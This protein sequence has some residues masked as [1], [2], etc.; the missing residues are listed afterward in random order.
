MVCD[1]VLADIHVC[2]NVNELEGQGLAYFLVSSPEAILC[3]G[4]SNL[5]EARVQVGEGAETAAVTL[6]LLILGVIAEIFDGL[7]NS[8]HLHMHA[9]EDLRF[10]KARLQRFTVVALGPYENSSA[11]VSIISIESDV[12]PN[13]NGLGVE[14]SACESLEASRGAAS[15]SQVI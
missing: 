12:S 4:E 13:V 3:V 8:N 10:D 9:R 15:V 5:P 7:W 1:V 6:E 11:A 2:R 14:F